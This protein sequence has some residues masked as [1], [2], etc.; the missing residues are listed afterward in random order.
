[1]FK[2][3]RN[4]IYSSFISET[5][6]INSYWFASTLSLSG[7]FGQ[8]SDSYVW[9]LPLSQYPLFTPMRSH[10]RTRFPWHLWKKISFRCSQFYILIHTPVLWS[11]IEGHW[12]NPN[13]A[14][15]YWAM[16]AKWELPICL[17]V[18]QPQTA[19]KGLQIAQC[20]RD[21]LKHPL[22]LTFVV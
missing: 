17:Q 6:K 16:R 9:E 3:R 11:A 10:H 1:M 12:K 14:C 20:S 4:V 2:K 7:F 15:K 22:P 8:C 5:W 18:S 19:A 21:I 13:P